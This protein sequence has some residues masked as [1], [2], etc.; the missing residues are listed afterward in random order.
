MT[1]HKASKDP[2]FVKKIALRIWSLRTEIEEIVRFRILESKKQDI[3][4]PPIDDLIKEYAGSVAPQ[5]IETIFSQIKSKTDK[6]NGDNEE[7][8]KEEEAEEESPPKEGEEEKGEEN[9]VYQRKPIIPEERVTKGKTLLSEINMVYLFL[10]CENSFIEGKNIVIEFLIPKTFS[11]NAEVLHC[12]KHTMRSRVISEQKL[13]FR[14]C[15]KFTFLKPGEKSLLRQFLSSIEP[16]R[17]VEAPS[18]E[19]GEKSDDDFGE[20][21]D[22]DM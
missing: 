17:V 4:P 20:L 9:I 14:A 11:L 12:R 2:V 22:L 15:F 5:D 13:P 21:D 16:E 3:D 18:E 7:E 6:E 1:I 8:E 10:F 19:S